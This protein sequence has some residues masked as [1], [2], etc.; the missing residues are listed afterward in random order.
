MNTWI[1][2]ALGILNRNSKT[3][4]NPL[5]K[6]RITCSYD[7]VEIFK[8]YADA[9][10][11]RPKTNLLS[12]VISDNVSNETNCQKGK[13][14]THCLGTILIKTPNLREKVCRFSD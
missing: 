5:H 1:N 6:F 2:S 13:S 8:K 10:A 3:I 7:E 14:H 11:A 12:Q 4:L 9:N